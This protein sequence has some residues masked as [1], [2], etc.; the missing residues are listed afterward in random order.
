M[1][2]IIR[3]TLLI[4]IMIFPRSDLKAGQITDAIRE[5]LLTT[6]KFDPEMTE[7]DCRPGLDSITL[8]DTTE[9]IVSCREYPIPSGYFPLKVLL[10]DGSGEI[11]NISTS[12]DISFFEKVLVSKG[13]IKS[14]VPLSRGDFTIERIEVGNL[15]GDPI[16]DYT[17]LEG[18]RASKTIQRGKALTEEMIEPIPVIKR[19]ERV[20]L[21]YESGN[22]RVEAY[23]IARKDAVKGEMVE[24]KNT[25]SGK[26]IC[27]RAVSEG[28]VMVER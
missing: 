15:I 20:K 14:R 24:V 19:G 21:I 4:S 9:V 1:K 17:L 27:G 26:Q 3:I 6:F 5:H 8:T 7:I 16:S 25:S 12:V 10:Q 2:N 11:R 18:M 23:G 13:R 28:I 22:L